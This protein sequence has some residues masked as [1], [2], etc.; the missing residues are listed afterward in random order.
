MLSGEGD[1]YP[2]AQQRA[3]QRGHRTILSVPL[4]REDECIGVIT[5]RRQEVKPFSDKQISLLETFANQA[6]IAIGNARLFEQLQARTKELA[7]SLE[8]LRT[9]QDRLVQ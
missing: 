8:E 9:A 1:Q 3:R 2:E 4:L 7:A 6:V 5:V